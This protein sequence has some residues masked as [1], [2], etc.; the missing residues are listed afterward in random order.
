MIDKNSSHYLL[1][2]Y[3]NETDY[4]TTPKCIEDSSNWVYLIANPI[5]KMT[6][7]GITNSPKE[8]LR[9]LQTS[10]GIE[11]LLLIAIEL[12]PDYDENPSYVEDYLHKY[13]KPKRGIGEWFNLS[14]KDILAIKNLFFEVIYGE[15]IIDNLKYCLTGKN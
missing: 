10:C 12:Q 7:I 3:K 9:K 6:K 4:K 1:D 15:N 5:N 11:L 13:F 14:I 2:R 8:R